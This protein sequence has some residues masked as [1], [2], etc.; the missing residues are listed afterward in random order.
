[1]T[2][3]WEAAVLVCKWT[4]T[5]CIRRLRSS[6]SVLCQEAERHKWEAREARLLTSLLLCEKRLAELC[7]DKQPAKVVHQ[8]EPQPVQ[9]L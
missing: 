1:M 5:G 6:N 2:E 7:T 8:K 4:S 9:S 3:Q